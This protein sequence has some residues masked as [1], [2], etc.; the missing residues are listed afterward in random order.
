MELDNKWIENFEMEEI[1]YNDFYKDDVKYVKVY[2]LLINKN[3]ILD[4]IHEENFLLEEKNILKNMLT[5]S[6]LTNQLEL[7]EIRQ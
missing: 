7:E 4:N 3:L 2:F 1:V 6:M 5:K